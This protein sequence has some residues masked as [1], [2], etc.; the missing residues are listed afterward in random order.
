MKKSLRIILL[1]LLM[2]VL[3]M[4][5]VHAAD[6]LTYGDLQYTVADNAI[7]IVGCAD[8]VETLTIPAQIDGVPVTSISDC[9]FDGKTTLKSLTLPEGITHLG[10][11]ILRGTDVTEITVPAS[12]N[13]IAWQSWSG[14]NGPFSGASNLKTITFAEGTTYIIEKICSSG[15]YES[16]LET[17]HFPSTL[18][19]IGN[20]AFQNCKKLKNI[21]IP[22]AVTRIEERAFQWCESLDGTVVFPAAVQTVGEYAYEGCTGID[23]VRFALNKN[24][25]F[26]RNI[27]RGAFQTCT[28]LQDVELTETTA[29]LGDDLF[30]GCSALETLI[31]PEGVTHLGV[32]MI[33]GTAITEITVP[34]SVKSIGYQSWSGYNGPFAGASNLKTITFAEGTTAIIEKICSSGHF[35][36]ALETVHLPSTLTK[37]GNYAFQNCK[38]LKSV[39]IPEAVTVI[40][41]RAFQWCDSL[42]GTMVFPAGLKT[43]GEYCF[44]GCVS[45][46]GARFARNET[47][48]FTRAIGNG[49]FQAGTALTDVELSTATATLGSNLFTGC[50]ALETLVLPEGITHMGVYLISGTSISKITVPASLK[51]NGYQNWSGYNGPFA[52]CAA[53]KTVIFAEG[54][55]RVVDMTCASSRFGSN[56]EKVYIPAS[57]E[58]IGEHAFDG[59]ANVVIYCE[60]NSAAERFAREKGIPYKDVIGIR[61]EVMIAETEFYYH[62]T[63]YRR[64]YCAFGTTMDLIL[65]TEPADSCVMQVAY[66]DS[67]GQWTNQLTAAYDE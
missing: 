44:E 4:T 22:E 43:L 36:S 62:V 8:G 48:G 18:T 19:R 15:H 5:Q 51:T 37:I 30:N 28:S 10:I 29:A 7:T 42:D 25:G 31:L 58:A 9:A 34:V 50:S 46:D 1:V 23:G 67:Y 53:L 64:G 2:A 11:Y 32:Y 45:L 17:V 20:H 27:E 24:E 59:C 39:T 6:P 14:Y 33:S 21:T 55:T 41:E 57:V 47:E 56:L 60:A 49:V 66:T 54:T 16:A 26:T 12:V 52:D 65:E 63:E 61:D 3:A 40:E 13:S 35:A 38:K